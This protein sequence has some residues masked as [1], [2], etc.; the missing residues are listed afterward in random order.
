MTAFA[1]VIG[2]MAV[3]QLHMTLIITLESIDP[4]LPSMAPRALLLSDMSGCT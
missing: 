3:L 4:C 1:L 2:F